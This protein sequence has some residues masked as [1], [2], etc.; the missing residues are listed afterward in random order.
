MS[1][2]LVAK[3]ALSETIICFRVDGMCFSVKIFFFSR[4]KPDL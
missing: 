3:N 2:F 1:V 4:T